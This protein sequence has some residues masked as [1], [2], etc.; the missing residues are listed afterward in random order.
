MR[1]GATLDVTPEQARK[2]LS[3]DGAA[4]EAVLDSDSWRFDGD[5]YIPEEIVAELCKQH[6]L[7]PKEYGFDFNL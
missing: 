4:L 6:G 3:G 7:D 1:L 2:I 5:S